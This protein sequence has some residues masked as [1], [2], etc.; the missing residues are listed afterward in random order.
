MKE[1]EDISSI[2]SAST[3]E[4]TNKRRSVRSRR[5]DSYESKFE[6][7]EEPPSFSTPKTAGIIKRIPDT[8]KMITEQCAVASEFSVHRGSGLRAKTQ[9][10]LQAANNVECQTPHKTN[11]LIS[12]EERDAAADADRTLTHESDEQEPVITF[13]QLNNCCMKTNSMYVVEEN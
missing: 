2:S 4:D 12:I 6:S 3:D 8:F 11:T 10:V 7:D 5:Y 13:A 1:L 9:Q